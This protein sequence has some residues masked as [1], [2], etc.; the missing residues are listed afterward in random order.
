VLPAKNLA[1]LRLAGR[2]KAPVPTRS[3][4]IED[5]LFPRLGLGF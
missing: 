5:R 3:Y 2:A 1:S 4:Y